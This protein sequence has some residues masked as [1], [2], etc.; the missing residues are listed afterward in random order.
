MLS[1]RQAVVLSYIIHR[2]DNVTQRKLE[3]WIAPQSHVIYPIHTPL[4]REI[5]ALFPIDS[6][7]LHYLLL[8]QWAYWVLIFTPTADQD[9]LTKYISSNSSI[10]QILSK[11]L[12][13]YKR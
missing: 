6:T 8:Q 5:V 3:T 13:H 2:N 12:S 1:L 10:Q 9:M 4:I 7:P 11:S